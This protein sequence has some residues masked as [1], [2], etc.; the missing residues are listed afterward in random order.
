VISWACVCTRSDLQR[1]RF[2]GEI[3]NRHIARRDVANSRFRKVRFANCRSRGS[4]CSRETLARSCRCV[5]LAAIVSRIIRRGRSIAPSKGRPLLPALCQR[6]HQVMRLAPFALF[7]LLFYFSSSFLS[8]FLVTF[9]SL[10]KVFPFL[11]AFLS[12]ERRRQIGDFEDGFIF[13]SNRFY[14]H[15]ALLLSGLDVQF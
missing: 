8:A 5:S 10:N 4:R 12:T 6:D 14:F 2:V 7:S 15:I 11:V 1:F 3:E 9:R 13:V